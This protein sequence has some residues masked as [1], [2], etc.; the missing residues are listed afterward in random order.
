MQLWGDAGSAGDVVRTVFLR[1]GAL[2]ALAAIALPAH[3]LDLHSAEDAAEV[4]IKLRCSL[5]TDKDIVSWWKGT[6]FA[7]E[8]GQAPSALMGFEGYNICRS[9]RLTDGTWRMRTRELVFYRDLASGR[10]L[11]HWDNPMT[12]ARNSVLAIANDPVNQVFNPPGRPARALPWV[13]MGDQLMLTLNIPLSYPNPLQPEAYPRESSGAMYVG[14]EHFMF[15]VSRQEMENPVLASAPVT[16]SW[17]RTGPWLP[18]MEVGQR[19]GGLLYIAQGG[20]LNAL[21]ELPRDILDLVHSRYPEYASAPSTWVTPN[22][23]SWT[24][25]RDLKHPPESKP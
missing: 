10:I 16:Y 17:T 12:G 13:E 6:L 21:D 8:P 24:Y 1:A 25:Y 19:P 18:W 7:Q 11:E 2:L 15:F 22:V 14:S 9:E 4:M 23:T 20:K 3:A 5:D